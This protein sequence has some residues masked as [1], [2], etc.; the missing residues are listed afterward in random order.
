M[1]HPQYPRV[2]LLCHDTLQPFSGGGATLRGLFSAFPP[3]ALFSVHNDGHPPDACRLGTTHRITN[4]DVRYLQPV[5]LAHALNRFFWTTPVAPRRDVGSNGQPGPVAGMPVGSGVRSLVSQA[6]YLRLSPA[7]L[8]AIRDFKPDLLYGWIGD[9]LWGR[10][11]TWLAAE[12]RVPYVVHFMDNHIGLVT[13]PDWIG[14]LGA[15]LLRRQI[16]RTVAGAASVLAI[17]D[18]MA[19]AYAERWRRPVRA[20]HGVMRIDGW[21][22]PAARQSGDVCEL[23]FTG[24]I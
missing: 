6:G 14:K 4:D 12:L 9:P 10:T 21:P 16:D 8:A 15:R 3:E 1:K 7:V 5:G 2:L 18:A 20:F 17:S 13:P 11:L 19:D 23:A 22:A 24:S